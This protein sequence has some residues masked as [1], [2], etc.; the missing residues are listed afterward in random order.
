LGSTLDH[1]SVAPGFVTAHEIR[2]VPPPLFNADR[3]D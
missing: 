3:H 2:A 1:L